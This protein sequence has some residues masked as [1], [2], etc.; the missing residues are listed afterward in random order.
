MVLLNHLP[1]P[2]DIRAKSIEQLTELLKQAS[3]NRVGEKRARKLKEAIHRSRG[4]IRGS[5]SEVKVNIEGVSV[6][7]DELE[8]YTNRWRKH[9]K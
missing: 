6:Y 7:K 3:K 8:K 5:P 1:F 2:K 9:Y 4:R